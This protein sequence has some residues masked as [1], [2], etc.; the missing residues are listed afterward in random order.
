MFFS[1][2][3]S[4]H[5]LLATTLLA[6]VGATFYFS[7]NHP[8]TADLA[9]LHYSAWLINEKNF[10]LYRDIFD[11]NFPAPYLFHSILGNALGYEALPLRWVDLFLLTTLGFA[12]WKI[13]SPLS[14]PAAITG[15]NLF[16]LLYW[17]NGGE[18]VLERDVLALIPAALAFAIVCDN[19][20]TKNIII[21]SGVLTAIACS[22]KPNTIVMMP[23]LLWVLHSNCAGKKIITIALFLLSMLFVALIPFSWAIT[24]GGWD[25]FVDIYRHY[26][27]IYANSRYDLWH[28]SSSAERWQMLLSQYAQW[29]GM[30]LLLAAP[31]LLWARFLHHKNSVLCK[32]ITQLAAITFSFTLYE[33]IA[34][35][36]WL[37][38]MFPSAYW[39]FLCFAL[40]LTTPTEQ[41][42][43]W[44]KTV[45]ILLLIP[46]VGLG[47]SLASWTL[48][49]M[50][51][52]HQKEITAP[53][54]WRARQAANY[55]QAQH[56]QPE[57]TVQ[58]LD[59]AGDGQ[60][61]LLMAK[62][63]S[64][65]RFLIDVPLWMQPDSQETQTL[66]QNFLQNLQKK[67]P[68]YIVY[69]EQ[70][71]HP[72]G[73]N[74]LKEFKPLYEWINNHYE[75]TEQREAAYIIYRKKP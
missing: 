6:A 17:V 12:S 73:G 21:L 67:N 27:P 14:K 44:K 71:L 20:I 69:F 51:Q 3:R 62:A 2:T 42:A 61:A 53:E 64:A 11:I 65:T 23:V 37:N 13:I 72:G 41:S 34:G 75:I 48:P 33:A 18:F 38:H 28:Y 16:C 4:L 47:W 70:F 45:A 9:M 74:R 63:T 36:F 22:M 5:W 8:I 50:Q 66:R 30:S 46:C 60:A 40:L 59:M 56:L 57:D 55:L 54:D 19:K 26:L 10:V 32:R 15:F 68:V 29:G 49:L 31:G 35:K 39:S 24:Q 52:A 1:I 7:L 43:T 58:V 25:S